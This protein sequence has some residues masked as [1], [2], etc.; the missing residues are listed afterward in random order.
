MTATA[1]RVQLTPAERTALRRVVH[2][3]TATVFTHRRA[4]ILLAA[5]RQPDRPVPTD[6]T[7]A[8]LVGVSP[9]TV[10][11]T[12]ARWAEAG[13]AAT[14]QP[15]SRGT[16]GRTRFDTAT[17]ARIAKV[18]CSAPPPGYARWSLRLLAEELVTLEIVPQICPETLRT[19]LK[20]TI[21][22][23]G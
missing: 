23:H 12:R 3:S 11:R 9:R 18:A 13:V 2:Q 20:K 5:D 8:A 16:K 21:S 15:R 10:A 6:A 17:Q 1:H 22:N 7:I 19:T 4:S 14:L